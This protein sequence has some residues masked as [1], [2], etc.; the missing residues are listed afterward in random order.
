MLTPDLKKWLIIY[1]RRRNKRRFQ[2]LDGLP[3]SM[4]SISEEQDR[5]GRAN[6]A[7]GKVT[8]RIR[9]MISMYMCNRGI[10]YMEYHWVRDFIK[11]LMCLPHEQWLGLNLMKHHRTKGTIGINTRGQLARELDSLLDKDIHNIAEKYGWMLDLDTSDKAV[12][13]MWELQYTVFE[14][15]AA[16][17]QDKVVSERTGGQ[18]KDFTKHCRMSHVYVPMRNVYKNDGCTEEERSRQREKAKEE[19]AVNQEPSKQAK[20]QGAEE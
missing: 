13:S 1:I 19:A 20:H 17:A 6:F 18:T 16:K 10:M 12:V 15:K 8:I 5:V 3:E 14:L 11:N 4:M 2:G 7:E 9:G